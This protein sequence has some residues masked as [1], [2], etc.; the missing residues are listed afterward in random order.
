MVFVVFY[1]LILQI[2]VNGEPSCYETKT[3]D[4]TEGNIGETKHFPWLGVLR[5]HS[6]DGPTMKIGLTGLVLIK[7]NYGVANA[8]DVAGVHKSDLARF[9]SDMYTK[10]QLQ[11]QKSIVRDNKLLEKA[12]YNIEY[13]NRDLCDDFYNRVGFKY[14]DSFYKPTTYHCGV[15][16]NNKKNCMWDNGMVLA[17]NT[18]GTWVLIGFSIKGPGCSAPIRFLDMLSYLP[19]IE[20]STDQV[21][22]Y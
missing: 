1:L 9:N 7:H 5:V 20:T 13:V 4:V 17:S 2:Y 18:T 12:I 21:N 16:K 11:Y 8:H 22:I 6:H 19:W 3:P 15:A 14:E 10:Y